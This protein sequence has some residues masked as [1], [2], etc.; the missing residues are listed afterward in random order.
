MNRTEIPVLILG[1]G[2]EI[3]TDDG[4][5]PKLV[6]E[7]EKTLGPGNLKYVTSATGGMD[8]IDLMAGYNKAIIIDGIRT[9]EGMPGSVYRYTPRD[10]RETLH[11]S[12]FHDVSFLTALELA[13]KINLKM[14]RQIH[15]I[16]IEIVEDITFSN[17]FS[18][19]I[20]EKYS[21]IFGTVL[22]MVTDLT[23]N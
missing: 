10:F 20:R 11:L 17:D 7:L 1:I 6:H 13:E 4:I 8:V 15:I 2:N 22:E 5:G 3:L 9:R 21:T 23:G 16:A 12:S 14:P 18:P 19:Q